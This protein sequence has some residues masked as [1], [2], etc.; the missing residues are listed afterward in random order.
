V[1]S[2]E[3]VWREKCEDQAP[4][5]YFM[6]SGRPCI[7]R[8]FRYSPE[9]VSAY[10]NDPLSQ[11]WQKYYRALPAHQMHDFKMFIYVNE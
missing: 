10:L 5:Q 7:T 6:D 2:Q 9:L 8:F 11:Q 4:T 3:L 1:S